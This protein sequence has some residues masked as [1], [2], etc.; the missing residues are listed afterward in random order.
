MFSRVPFVT[1]CTQK[2]SWLVITWMLS[3]II[4]ISFRLHFNQSPCIMHNMINI[5]FIKISDDCEKKCTLQN[6]THH[7]V[8]NSFIKSHQYYTTKSSAIAEWDS[9]CY[10][11]TVIV[12][13]WLTITVTLNMICV[14]SISLAELSV[15][16]IM[17]PVIIIIIIINLLAQKHDKVTRA[18]KQIERDIKDTD[19]TIAALEK[20]K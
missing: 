19:A 4:T 12:V 14:N 17:Y 5:S 3:D 20:Y 9:S 8:V 10:G 2:W 11:K 13:D 6:A 15:R 1:H 18:V 16:G 7:E